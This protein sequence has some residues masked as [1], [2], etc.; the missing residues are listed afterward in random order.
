MLPLSG[1]W[2]LIAS[3]RMST[4][5]PE[6]SAS[7]AYSTWAS[8]DV[9]GQ[10]QVPQPAAAGRLLE[11]ARRPAGRCGRRA[12]PP[13]GRRRSSASAGSTRSAGTATA[14]GRAPLR[15]RVG[16]KSI[17]APVQ[18]TAIG[19]NPWSDCPRV[20]R[21]TSRCFLT[22]TLQSLT[23]MA[24]DVGAAEAP[25]SSR[26][27]S[28]REGDQ[29]VNQPAAQIDV[30]LVG[31]SSGAGSPSSS[32]GGC[33]AGSW[34]RSCRLPSTLASSWS[35]ARSH[36]HPGG[37]GAGPLVAAAATR[38]RSSAMPSPGPSTRSCPSTAGCASCARPGRCDR[39]ARRNDHSDAGLRRR[40]PRPPGRHPRRGRPA[41]QPVHRADRP[42][43][44]PTGSGS[45]RRWSASMR[46]TTRGWPRR[47]S[48]R[49][50]R[51]G[52]TCTKSSSCASAS[53]APRTRSSR[54]GW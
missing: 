27:V 17:A 31:R 41:A 12:R 11:L 19:G 33:S 51:S 45:R 47:W 50:T 1:A 21:R 42:G 46:A 16:W 37:D 54:S 20:M 36:A 23:I 7:A 32:S 34:T 30:D 26:S 40:R 25:M 8:P 43:F 2:Q 10:E 44:G 4:D 28:R 35:R 3:G 24:S 15:V 6:I 13:R 49:T 14:R 18:W 5:Q 39:T 38:T 29:A 48:T 53:A 9:D 22:F 52:C